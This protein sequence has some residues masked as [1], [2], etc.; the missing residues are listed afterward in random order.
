MTRV[1]YMFKEAVSNLS[2]N[3]LVVLR[4]ILA[5]FISLTLTF[6]TLVFGEVVRVN[7]LRW[8][9]DVR[10]IAFL[11]EDMSVENTAEL[12]AEVATWPQVDDV[13]YVSKADAYE[14]ALILFA[15]NDAML[16]VLEQ[17]PDLLPR[18]FGYSLPIPTTTTPSSRV[19]NRPRGREGA[20]RRCRDRCHDR[21][22]RWAPT[23]VL[24]SRGSTR[25][26]SCSFDRE[27]HP[28]GDIRPS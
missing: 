12:Q 6:G 25:H 15:N 5:V 13:F 21:P 19:C 9:E 22:A 18:R 10:V 16:S 14:E 27:H 28:H 1:S 4:A 17:T 11:Q 2:R 3:G 8:A 20:E 24:D 26:R 23:D 7:T